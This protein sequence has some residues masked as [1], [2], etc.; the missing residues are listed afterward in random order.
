[1]SSCTTRPQPVP[2]LSN[3]PSSSS[4]ATN[5]AKSGN[6]LHS[7]M[8]AGSNASRSPVVQNRANEGRITIS[9]GSWG[10]SRRVRVCHPAQTPHVLVTTSLLSRGLYFSPMIKHVFIVD[11]PRN[12]IDFLHR[13]GCAGRAGQ[14]GKVAVFGRAKGSGSGRTEEVKE[15]VKDCWIDGGGGSFKIGTLYQLITCV[16]FI[17]V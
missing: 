11:K 13:A 6:W 7:S 8:A 4:S 16:L 1:M 9:T 5:A 10:L 14:V 15:K 3:S 17:G 12:M 2:A